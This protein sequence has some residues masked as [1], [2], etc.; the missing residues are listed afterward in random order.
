MTTPLSTLTAEMIEAVPDGD[1]KQIRDMAYT[2]HQGTVGVLD[3]P[4]APD[5][6]RR[7]ELLRK[8]VILKLKSCHGELNKQISDIE[9]IQRDLS[10]L[11][12]W[13]DI[14]RDRIGSLAIQGFVRE[15]EERKQQISHA[16][17]SLSQ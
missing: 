11:R 17:S 8:A 1:I 5:D 4:M 9:S 12:G 16:R 10:N 3:T 13:L 7:E 15:S 2:L 6:Y 14:D